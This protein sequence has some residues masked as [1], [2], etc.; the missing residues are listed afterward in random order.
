M[1]LNP[2]FEKTR[3][4]RQ[5]HRVVIE[6]FQVHPRKPTRKYVVANF[7]AQPR[8]NPYP[9]LL[10]RVRHFFLLCCLLG[11]TDKKL[12]G[13]AEWRVDPPAQPDSGRKHYS[14][15]DIDWR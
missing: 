2:A 1:R 10:I 13:F 15:K 3:R 4:H 8:L 11:W 6:G 5:P 9:T 14:L 7:G 12:L